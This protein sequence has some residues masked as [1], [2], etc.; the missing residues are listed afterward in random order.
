MGNVLRE[1]STRRTI[2]SHVEI[3]DSFWTRFI[4]L[5]GRRDLATGHGLLII[6]CASIHTCFVRFALDVIFLDATGCVLAVRRNVKPWRLAFAPRGT[7]AIF[8]QKAGDT[9][10]LESGTQLELLAE[11]EQ[12]TNRASIQFLIANAHSCDQTLS[13]LS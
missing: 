2:A 5:Q 12:Q 9:P 11:D 7:F 6:P 8:E 3:A 4:G 1:A 13:C 10:S